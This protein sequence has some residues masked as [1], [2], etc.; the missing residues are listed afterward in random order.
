[1]FL[2]VDVVGG[3][4]VTDVDEID[5]DTEVSLK[6]VVVIVLAA[7]VLVLVDVI[8]VDVEVVVDV[9]VTV[10]E[11]GSVAHNSG[12]EVPSLYLELKYPNQ[13]EV[14]SSHGR[15]SS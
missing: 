14:L 15:Q 10:V 5:D 4:A 7:V 3:G 11:G 13:C 12:V 2:V 1:M 8:D 9:D 6:L